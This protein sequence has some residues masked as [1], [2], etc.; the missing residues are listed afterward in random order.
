MENGVNAFKFIVSM[1][2]DWQLSILKIYFPKEIG[3]KYIFRRV[4]R[5]VRELDFEHRI[6][7]LK[8]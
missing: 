5:E 8:E 3:S 4:R 6:A 2:W 1:V 7:T